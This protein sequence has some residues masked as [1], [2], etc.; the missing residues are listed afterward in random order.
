[1]PGRLGNRFSNRK[2]ASI[3][4]FLLMS[5]FFVPFFGLVSNVRA[6][7]EDAPTITNE[8]PLNGATEVYTNP[9]LSVEVDDPNDNPMEVIFESDATGDW[10]IIESF[11]GVGDGV[12]SVIP[13]E[14]NTLGTSFNWRVSASSNGVDWGVNTYSFT[15]TSTIL[16]QKWVSY[17]GSSGVH[18][19]LIADINDDGYE[20]VIHAGVGRLDAFNALTGATIWSQFDSGMINWAKPEMG[21]IDGDGDLEIVTPIET[22]PGIRSGISVRRAVDGVEIWRYTDELGGIMNQPV[23]ADIDGNGYYTIFFATQ[24]I[25]EGLDSRGRLTALYYDGTWL[26]ETFSWRPCGGGLSLADYDRDGRFEIYMGDRDENYGDGGYGAGCVSFWADTLEER[27]ARRDILCSSQIPMLIDVFGNDGILEV[28]IGEQR[29]P[30]GLAVLDAS[31]G[32]SIIQDFNNGIP[33]HYQSSIGDIDN[34]GHPE[35]CAADGNHDYNGVVGDYHDVVAFDVVDWTYDYR[36][37]DLGLC[38]YG[39]Q[40]ADVTGDGQLEVLAATTTALHVIGIVGGEFALLE[41]SI[42]FPST[43]HLNYA[44]VQDIDADGYNELVISGD[45]GD[46]YAFDTPARRPEQRARS[47]V[48]F[49]SERRNGVAEYVPPPGGV[50]PVIKDPIPSDGA[51]DVPIIISQLGFTLSDFQHDL[52]DY[53]VTTT[54]DIGSGSGTSVDNGQYTVDISGLEY[55]K[56]YSWTVTATDGTNQSVETFTFTTVT[57]PVWW[58][59]EWQYRKAIS[60]DPLQVSEDQTDFPVLVDIV[61]SNLMAMAQTDGDDIVFVDENNVKLSYEIEFYDS[62][63]GHLTAWVRLPQVSST[64]YTT[65][66]MYYGNPAALNQEDQAAVW[67]TSYKLVLHLSEEHEC[68]MW[69]MVSDSLPTDTVL[70]HLIYDTDSLK[71]LSETANRNGWGLVWYPGTIPEIRRGYPAAFDDPNFDLAAN[72]MAIS[73]VSVGVGHIRAAA[74]GGIPEDGDPH[75]FMRYKNGKWWAFSH[76]GVLDKT[77]LKNLIGADYLAANPP[78]F[79]VGGSWD[80]SDVI[81]TDLYELYVLK[82]IEESNWDVL[83]GIAKAVSTIPSSGGANFILTDGTTIWGFCRYYS[84]YYYQNTSPTYSVVASQPPDPTQPGW[85]GPMDDYS[86]VILTKNNAPI[87]ID[88]IRQYNLLVDPMF[89]DSDSSTILRD[90]GAGQDWYESRNNVPTLLYLDQTDVGGNIG[91]KA[92]FTASDSGNAYLT[93]EFGAAQTGVFSVQ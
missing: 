81:D 11:V 16:T 89:D 49:Y 82:C 65:F 61:D 80:D 12:Y 21:D 55:G 10:E 56:T 23:M 2:I 51:I 75:P 72:E 40:L 76:N 22:Q 60:I 43:E 92:G 24:D 32:S 29:D 50:A 90:D 52:M 58:D 57:M 31:D 4:V 14:L 36:I 68:R 17:A 39:P 78:I 74:S 1:M 48:T 28:V 70:N 83:T 64:E 26:G 5:S 41:P 19:V 34:D 35:V 91:K 13:M 62:T 47:E 85:S 9:I 3:M 79:P 59:T 53:T 15:T 25:T 77:A 66:Y 18:G 33:L 93:Q 73:G 84:L 54:P 46:V 42:N 86:L 20:E 30:P 69:G 45:S 44:V 7:P 38:I 63:D 88:D 87:L 71:E 37:S 67:D 8:S 27:W 6:A